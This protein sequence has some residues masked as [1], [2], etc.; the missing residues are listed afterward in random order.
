VLAGKG[1]SCI[2]SLVRR[3][4][5]PVPAPA[6]PAGADELPP[7][8]APS[9]A[10]LMKRA[11]EKAP[12]AIITIADLDRQIEAL[13]AQEQMWKREAR[14]FDAMVKEVQPQLYALVAVKQSLARG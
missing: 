11:R 13:R 7:R 5:L 14:R 1:A 3:A 9:G 12:T 8:G 2:R 6:L 10:E 4:R